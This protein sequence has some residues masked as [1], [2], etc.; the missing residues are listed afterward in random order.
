M[1]S[2]YYLAQVIRLYRYVIDNKVSK[3]Y[4]KNRL[5]KLENRKTALG[6]FNGNVSLKEMAYTSFDVA[7]KKFVGKIIGFDGQNLVV[8]VR[9]YFRKNDKLEIITP[10]LIRP[11][12]F[13]FKYGF[14]ELNEKVTICNK[15]KTVIKIPFP[16]SITEGYVSLKS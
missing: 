6:F 4:A 15:P 5:K 3:R 10:T 2:E 14:D 7:N 12:Y 9:N 16:K 13:K 1:K 11:L 8:E